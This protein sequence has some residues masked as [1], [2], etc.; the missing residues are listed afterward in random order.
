M[1]AWVRT[2]PDAKSVSADG[3]AAIAAAK[4]A[5]AQIATLILPADTAWNE[6]DG[7]AQVPAES[8][9]ANYS[10][11]AVDH[12]A[13]VLRNGGASTLLLMTGSALTEHGLALAAQIAG[14]TGCKVMGQT[15]NP[16][17]ARGK[18]RF[19]IDR[20]P[21]VIEQALPILKDFQEHR[22]GRGQRSRRVLRLSEQAEHAQTSGLRSASHDFRR[23]K[24]RSRAGSAGRRA[25]RAA[26]RPA[27]AEAGRTGK[28]DRRA[29]ARL[30]RAGDCDGDPGKRHRG[31]RIRHHR[32]RLLSADGGGRAARLAAEHGRLD[33]LLDRRSRPA[34][35]WRAPTAR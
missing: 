26:V 5:P 21:Y 14:K 15:Y 18:G 13:K 32:P 12:A 25:S 6:A 2:S 31:R 28:T 22:A 24:F 29:D 23:R 1:S 20:I 19:A 33:R 3:A 34:P 30:D 10:A 8:Q 27:A 17:M 35:R 7:I 4:S 11:Q 9:R 16:R